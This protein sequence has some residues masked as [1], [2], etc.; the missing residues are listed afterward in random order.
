MPEIYTY[1]VFPRKAR[2]CDEERYSFLASEGFR[3]SGAERL[4]PNSYVQEAS[5][6]EVGRRYVHPTSS[7]NWEAAISPRQ[8]G[9]GN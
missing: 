2:S 5:N 1:V 6:I 3:G 4:S 9:Q 7:S 8:L